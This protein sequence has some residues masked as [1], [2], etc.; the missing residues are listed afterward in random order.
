MVISNAK[1]TK[2]ILVTDPETNEV[3]K[4]SETRE[5]EILF[6]RGDLIV[7]VSPLVRV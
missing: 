5:F 1:E 6:L 7:V 3:T 2:Y 4:T